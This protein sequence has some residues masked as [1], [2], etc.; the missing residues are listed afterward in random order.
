[1]KNS[2][3]AKAVSLTLAILTVLPT[4]AACNQSGD[5]SAT[6]TAATTVTVPKKDPADSLYQGEQILLY[7]AN[8]APVIYVDAADYKQTVRAVGDLQADFERVTDKK[9][10]LFHTAEELSGADIAII[11]G[12]LGHSALIDSMEAE[13]IIGV[14]DIK[15]QW[16]AYSITVVENP[17]EGVEKAVVIAGSDKR[18]TIYGAYELS[19]QI[20]VSPWYYWSDVEIEHKDTVQLP[21]ATLSQV[22]MP[23]VKYRGIFLNDEEN[24]TEWSE[25]FATKLAPGKPGANAYAHVYELL[26]RLKANMLWPGMHSASGT[27]AFNKYLNPKTG[28]SYNAELADEYGIVMSS[29]HCEMLLRNNEGEWEAWCQANQGKYGLTK[30][31]NSWHS[32]YDYTVNAEA[33]NAYWEE[34]VARNYRFENVYM[35]GLRGVHDSGINCSNLADKSYKGKAT[36]V[37]KAVEAQLEILAKYEKKYEEETG[38]KVK[39]ETAYCVYKE[40]AEYF[41]YDLGLPKDC[42]LVYAEDNHGYIRSIVS[43]EDLQNYESFGMYYHVS[44]WGRPTSY[45]WI[46]NTPLTIIAEE[47]RKSYYTGTDDIWVLNVGDIKPA[48]FKVDYFMELGWDVDSHTEHNTEEYTAQFLQETFG[49][50]KGDSEQ[51]AATLTDFYQLMRNYY[52]EIID[53]HTSDTN[54][55][56]SVTNFGSEG[57]VVIEKLT[58]IYEESLKIYNGLP[59]GKKASYYEIFHYTVYSY[60]LSVE[61]HVYKEM[62]HLCYEQGRFAAA[63][64]Y[65]DLSEAAYYEILAQIEYFNKELMNGKWNKI[66]NPYN[67]KMDKVMSQIVGAPEL[68]RA[69]QADAKG[70]VGLSAEGQSG[71]DAVTLKFGSLNDDIRFVD[72]FNKGASDAAWALTV[73]SYVII[74]DAA[75]NRL[76][77][78][79]NGANVV[80][81]G[82]VGVEDRYF[83]SIDWEKFAAGE[84]K[85][86]VVTLTDD[87]GNTSTANISA[88]KHAIAPEKET[89]KGYY[90]ENGLVS[91]EAEHFTENVKQGGFEW[92]YIDGLG[93]SGGVMMALSEKNNGFENV[94]I[95]SDVA[96]NSPYL[97]YKIYFTNTGLYYGTFYRLP[98]LNESASGKSYCRTGWSLDGSEIKFLSGTTTADDGLN[99]AWG[100]MIKLHIEELRMNIQID[101]PG[102]HTLRIYMSNSLQA[103]D[104]IVFNQD[105]LVESRLDAPETYNTISWSHAPTANLPE[106][107]FEDVSWNRY[108]ALYDFTT[109]GGS[110]Q[111]GYTKV[112][113]TIGSLADKGWA[114]D[115]ISGVLAAFRSS[116]SKCPNVDKGFVYGTNDATFKLQ[117]PGAGRYGITVSVGDPSGTVKA[118]NMSITVGGKK[119]LSGISS[120]R[121]V[122]HYFFI[123]EAD[124]SG[125]VELK[126]SGSWIL[127]SLEVYTYTEHTTAGKG[128]FT[129]NSDGNIVIEVET[130]LEQSDAARTEGSTDGLGYEWME[131]AGIYGSGMFFG[132]NAGSSYSQTNVNTSKSA[133]MYFTVDVKEAGNYAVWALM[134]CSSLED[135]SV[136]MALTGKTALVKNDLDATDGYVWIQIGTWSGVA[137]GE[138]EL[139]VMGREDGLALDRIMLIPTGGVI[140]YSGEMVRADN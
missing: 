91:I 73:P 3:I 47:M 125:V 129:A 140:N 111:S 7:D 53:K 33:M 69:S 88:T 6:T 107:N 48:E 83:L 90:E 122:K 42:C 39:F 109:S 57:L 56:Y 21:V 100:N 103:F 89:V 118:E 2:I 1:M 29:S 87:F 11:V 81:E 139:T 34:S 67:S 28:V 63:N 78:K 43:E 97:E 52:P 38:E 13:G 130:A 80:Y 98:T 58:K 8:T 128:A 41:K 121:G 133:K 55:D 64:A 116:V 85:T 20:G 19:E 24:F 25:Q 117:L 99:T 37:K 102:W 95:S 51:F 71:L 138:T 40:A 12:T 44:Y 5:P 66:M 16:E 76:E 77:G 14:D 17:V 74:T 79:A 92:K 27:D 112:D 4:L 61:K 46:S 108:S 10:A 54:Y 68:K 110:V 86:G 132:P 131:V 96:N 114:W 72:I 45:L 22:E 115:T 124:E 120:D 31:N 32:S 93:R 126:L 18:G 123:V 26:L 15:G 30:V 65:A 49:L 136:I 59:E 105:A 94:R 106:I 23:D 135:D 62:N 70:G 50:T 134:K 60:L 75:G 101:E 113:N 36:V 119:C 137:A 84:T 104:K 127:G 35:I 82:T 9:P